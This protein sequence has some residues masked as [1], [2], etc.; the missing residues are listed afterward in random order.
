M[1]KTLKELAFHFR[2]KIGYMIAFLLLLVSYLFTL[3][4]ND[5]LMKQTGWVIHTNKVIKNT[6]MLIS[7]MKDAETGM[8][9]Y[10]TTGDTS[11]LQPYESSIP[12]VD[13]TFAALKADTRDDSIQQNFLIPLNSLIRER[14]NKIEFAI[15]YFPKTNY[16]ITDTLKNSFYWGKAIMDSIRSVVNAMQGHE[17]DLLASRTK[18]L[19]A[20]YKTLNILTITSLVVALIFALFGFFTYVKEYKARLIS[21]KKAVDYQKELQQRIVELDKVNAALLVMQRSEKFASTGRI[22]RTIAHEVRNP[23]TNIDLA[24]AQLKYDIPVQDE[25][26]EMLFGMMHRNSER[27]NQLISALL[28]ATRFTELNYFQVS[29]NSILDDALV[30]AKDRIELNGISVEKIYSAAIPD[31]LVDA[32]KIKIAF[33]N[34]IVNAIEAMESGKGLLQI[35]TRIEEDKCIVEITDNGHGMTEN[36]LSNVF[37][38]Y[39]STKKNGNGLGLTNT[40]NIILN[41]KGDISVTSKPGKGTTFVIKINFSATSSH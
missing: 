34:L 32:E 31:I 14:Y 7:G 5:Q 3:F 10:I 11:F 4:G 28:N 41:H 19:D 30:L 13:N 24:M 26:T 15:D 35:R 21:D 6:E 29:V 22:A 16:V 17:Q 40:A 27:I 33:L 2:I 23:L 18:E 1:I 20:R 39:F 36:Q 12:I 8:R 9:G 25:K 38:P 37:E